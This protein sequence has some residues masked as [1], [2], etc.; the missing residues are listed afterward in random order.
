MRSIPRLLVL[1]FL[2]GLSITA[3]APAERIDPGR[4]TAAPGD[5]VVWYDFSLLTVEGKGWQS[6]ES[7]YD[8]LPAKAKATV[9]PSVWNLSH[10][11]S[12]ICARFTTDAPLVQVRWTVLNSNLALPHMAATGVSGVDLYSRDAKGVWRFVQNGRPLKETNTAPFTVKPGVECI[13]YLP[14]YNGVKSVEIG[15]PPD[16]TISTPEPSARD[17]KKPVVFYG[18]SIT[19]GACASRPGM[20]FTNIVGRMLDTPVINLGFSGSG[21]M[22]TAMSDLLVELDPSVYVLDCIWNMTPQMVGERV[23]PFVKKLREARPDTPII[24]A[25]DCNFREISP[26][27]KGRILRD[28]YAKLRKDGVKKLYFLPNKGMMGNDW[29]GTVD[30]AHPNDLGMMRQAEVFAKALRKVK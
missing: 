14:L 25:E 17:R 11:S 27:E 28:V 19:H 4:G 22:E 21:K 9:P 24:L 12:G 6:G 13:L 16:K 5:S 2:F 30:G 26:T 29:E 23:E 18:T 15:I 3:I 20:S 7:Y 1:V 8:R 10:H